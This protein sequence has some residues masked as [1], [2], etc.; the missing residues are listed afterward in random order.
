M[1]E[2][3]LDENDADPNVYLLLAMCCQG[4]GDLEAAAEVGASA[5][6]GRATRVAL[7][8]RRAGVQGLGGGPLPAGTRC[9]FSLARPRRAAAPSLTPSPPCPTHHSPTPAVEDGLRLCKKLGLPAADETR[10]GFEAMQAEL[11]AMLKE[12]AA[13]AGKGDA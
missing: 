10:A 12:D 8:G 13:A 2:Q 4:G 3:L 11:A 7:P 6:Q 9:W 5:A 1:L